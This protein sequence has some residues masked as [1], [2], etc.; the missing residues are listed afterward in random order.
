MVNNKILFW[1]TV[2]IL[3]ISMP[4]LAA[5]WPQWRGPFFNGSTNEK[6]LPDSFSQTEGIIWV[7]PL[8]GPSGATPVICNSRIFVSSTVRGEANFVAMCFDARNGI[9]LW[10][11]PIGSDTR[12]F[13]RN[14]MASPSPVTDGKYVF[15]LY[16]SGHLAGF[17]YE[18]NKLWSRNIEEEYGNL[19]LQF[20]YSS[21]P[22][23][24]QNKLFVLVVRR[25]KPYREPWSDTPLDS[26]MMAL[27]PQ[28]GKTIFEQQRKTNAFDEGME[29]YSTPTP[30]IRNGQTEIL[31]TGADFVTAHNPDTGKELWRFEY[32]TNKVRDSRVI[33]S[34]VTGDDLIFGARHKHGG[35]FALQPPNL[36]NP[37]QARIIW[38]YNGPSP[39]ASTPLY[40][41]K[42]LYVLN[43]IR[44][45]KVVTCLEPNTG[46][47]IWQGTIGGRGP[48]RASLTGA[49]GK[50]YCINETGEVVV[51]AAGG[52]EFK[53]IF[54]TKIDEPR[55]QSS[56]AV[57]DG[58]LFIRTAENLYCIGK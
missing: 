30:F 6:N 42:R 31:N 19:A 7:S 55:I 25:N 47:Q 18:G 51:L 52:N 36:N 20:G 13:P 53:I 2:T 12:R 23:L 11:K 48:W 5:D 3:V 40:Y 37:S 1:T 10:E 43:G 45:G 41:Q 46:R 35:V 44:H 26:F 28:T 8:P 38:N 39:D 33:P 17:D 21:S 58:R 57:A 15:F 54:Q 29:T 27:N 32:H 16:G 14:N 24:Y 56:I 22:L 9:K 34:L 50:L 4:V 49:D